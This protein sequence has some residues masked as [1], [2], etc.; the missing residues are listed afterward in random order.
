MLE[1]G[2][3]E[4]LLFYFFVRKN[5]FRSKKYVSFFLNGTS[6]IRDEKK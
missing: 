1:G 5:T 4:L 2:G 6:Y 3:N